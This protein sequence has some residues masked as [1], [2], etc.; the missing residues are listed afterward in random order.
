[1]IGH[2]Q[3]KYKILYY[4]CHPLLAI[5][6][7]KLGCVCSCLGSASNHKRYFKCF[8]WNRYALLCHT[9]CRW[10]YLLF[11]CFSYTFLLVA[12]KAKYIQGVIINW[13][14][15]IFRA[16]G[17]FLSDIPFL[18]SYLANWLYYRCLRGSLGQYR[19]VDS[20]YGK[21]NPVYTHPGG[22]L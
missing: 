5:D 13:Y 21:I 10:I 3:N 19:E 12:K 6:Q 22:P 17:F 1:M 14:W 7:F 20:N 16:C 8:S 2:A 15:P 9:E 11:L 4:L 18:L